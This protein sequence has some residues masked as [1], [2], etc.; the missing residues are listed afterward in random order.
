MT[1]DAIIEK[2]NNFFTRKGINQTLHDKYIEYIKILV[3]NNVPIIFDF[4]H[5]RL[6]MGRSD[7]YFTPKE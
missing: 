4:N 2:W 3:K 6:L 5:L 7:L 1:S